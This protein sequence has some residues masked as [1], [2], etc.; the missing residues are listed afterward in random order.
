MLKR[1]VPLSA[2]VAMPELRDDYRE[3]LAALC[4]EQWSGWMRYFF[5]KCTQT[6]EGMLVPVGYVLSLRSLIDTPYADL[7]EGQ[8][9]NDRQEAD[10]I[11]AL[12]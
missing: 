10:R 5:D 4:H 8:K 11:L 2:V 1:T 12:R 7:P 6:P 3:Q 9:D